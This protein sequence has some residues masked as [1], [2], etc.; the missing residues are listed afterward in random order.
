MTFP[1]LTVEE[2]IRHASN[3]AASIRGE[4]PDI[5]V[6]LDR[7]GLSKIRTSLAGEVSWGQSRLLGIAMALSLRPSLL[8]LD[9]PFAG[10]SPAAADEVSALLGEVRAQGLALCVIDHEM[11]FLLPICDTLIVLAAGAKLAEG[12]PNKVIDLPEVR[13]AYLGT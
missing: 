2:N 8:L 13:A 9:E 7:A 12:R 6:V 10:L 4:G 3:M 1:G 5:D 11:G